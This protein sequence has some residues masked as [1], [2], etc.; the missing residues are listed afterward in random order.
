MMTDI[1]DR[2]YLAQD[3]LINI[4]LS[5][6]VKSLNRFICVCKSWYHIIRSNTF[7]QEHHQ[8]SEELLLVICEDGGKLISNDLTSFV[9]RDFIHPVR[10]PS[11]MDYFS[12]HCNGLFC[13]S[14]LDTSA[15]WNPANREIKILPQFPRA[16]KHPDY[17]YTG[18]R[19]VW[20]QRIDDYKVIVFVC[21]YEDN[22]RYSGDYPQYVYIY[23]LN[24]DSWKSFKGN[25]PPYSEHSCSDL[26]LDGTFYW[27]QH[28]DY[29]G[30]LF[31]FHISDEVFEEIIG[32]NC[33]TP[34]VY[35]GTALDKYNGHVA[36]IIGGLLCDDKSAVDIWVLVSENCWNKVV[37]CI[38]PYIKEFCALGIWEHGEIILNN[39]DGDECIN[40]YDPR[41]KQFN[42]QVIGVNG[43]FKRSYKESLV[44]VKK[45]QEFSDVF[46]ISDLFV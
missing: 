12:G 25:V 7:I 11:Q 34:Y 36:I 4:L 35:S 6:P 18:L 44:S 14:V 10:F 41:T 20:D 32:P 26:C 38:V 37:T 2:N 15:L 22:R 23:S 42:D 31:S 13:F 3:I 29:S 40:I 28:K 24:N 30:G 27:L 39:L 8:Q 5:L 1:I 46:N 21:E 17:A 33:L 43:Y 45:P 9:D 16:Y 19:L